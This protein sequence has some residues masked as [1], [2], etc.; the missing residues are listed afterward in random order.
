LI[1]SA[2]IGLSSSSLRENEVAAMA[3]KHALLTAW[4]YA[5]SN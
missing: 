4:Q 1:S 5:R 2:G 3:P